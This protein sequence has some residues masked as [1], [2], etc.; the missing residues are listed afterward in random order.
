MCCFFSAHEKNCL[1][2][3]MR[4]H[5]ASSLWEQSKHLNGRPRLCVRRDW[6]WTDSVHVKRIYHNFNTIIQT[7]CSEH[8]GPYKYLSKE[9]RKSTY[10]R[11]KIFPGIFESR[12]LGEWAVLLLVRTKT[13]NI[14][15]TRVC[16]T[17][18]LPL[19]TFYKIYFPKLFSRIFLNF[20]SSNIRHRRFI[21]TFYRKC[22]FQQVFLMY[23]ILISISQESA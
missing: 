18:T 10:R 19:P 4:R 14:Q 9:W 8:H 12:V 17:T 20:F 1:N 22:F 11:K 23:W 6:N 2:I 5:S 21:L 15:R 3:K 13:A 7:Y 16:L